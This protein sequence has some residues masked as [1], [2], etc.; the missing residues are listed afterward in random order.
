MYAVIMASGQ[1]TRLWPMSRVSKPKQFHAML[2]RNTLIQDTYERLLPTFA[3]KDIFVTVTKDYFEEAKKQLPGIPHENFIVEPYATGTLG[4]CALAIAKLYSINPKGNAVF[5][6]S[7]HIITEPKEFLRIV[8]FAET[9]VRKYPKHIT[10]IGINPTRPDTG[11]GYIQMDSQIESFDSLKA[12]SVKRFVEKPDEKTAE[13]YVAAWEYLW[14]GGMFA[15]NIGHI[16]SLYEK[17]CPK[18]L[19]AV[20]EIIQADG[21]NEYDKIAGSRYKEIDRTSV[22]YAISEKEKNILV[23]PGDFGWSDVGS[24]GTLSQVLREHHNSFNIAKGNHI[25]VDDKDCLVLANHKL[26]AT[27]GL[28]DIVVIDTEDA[29]L[30]C[31]GNKS[32]KV[33]DLIDKLK[34]EGKNLYL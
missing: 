9:L 14:N 26:I 8:D 22:D 28:E 10:L 29:I 3:I 5:L 27:V 2:G 24:W 23:I 21:S 6:P 1:G 32:Q 33:K 16:R 20:T 18:T 17:Y 12:F 34:A 13:R 30:I 19:K 11:M 15:W 4:T 25:G 7:D 31:R